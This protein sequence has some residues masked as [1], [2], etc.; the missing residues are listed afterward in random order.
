MAAALPVSEKEKRVAAVTG[1][2]SGIGAQLTR[3]LLKDGWHVAAL[4][5]QAIEAAD[6]LEYSRNG[7]LLCTQLDVSNASDWERVLDQIVAHFGS[8]NVLINNAGIII[9]ALIANCTAE[10]IDRHVD[11]NLKGVMY[12][13]SLAAARMINAAKGGHIINVSSMAGIAPVPGIGAYTASKFGVRAYSLVASQELKEHGIAVTCVCPD[14]VNTP[15]LDQQLHYKE[16]AITFSGPGALSP[17]SVAAAIVKSLENRPIELIIPAHRGWIS[18]LA[19]MFP[20]LMPPLKRFM[21]KRGLRNAER[22]RRA[23]N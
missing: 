7:Q 22:I 19:S 23:A 10:Q 14:L 13:T 15:M 11:I 2:A 4:D 21:E 17:T 12:G 6:L 18:K 16:A 9:P 1:A 20:W 8:L 3:H 5:V